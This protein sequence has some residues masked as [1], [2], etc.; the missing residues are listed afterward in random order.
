M[1]NMESVKQAREAIERKQGSLLIW[2][3]LE[4]TD[5]GLEDLVN[6]LAGKWKEADREQL[7]EALR[8][9]GFEDYD[10]RE[11]LKLRSNDLKD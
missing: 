11:L 4:Q 5:C 2:F 7:K 6:I 9:S 8:E 10:L 3:D 1:W